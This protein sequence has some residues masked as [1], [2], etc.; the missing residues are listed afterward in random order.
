MKLTGLILLIAIT[1]SHSNLAQSD[2]HTIKVMS[3]NIRCAAC[4]K[5]SDINH[6]SK[7]KY[8]TAELIKKY[9]P[10]LIGLQEAEKSQIDDLF[11]LLDGYKWIGVGRDDGKETGEANAVFY[12][13]D[14]F[15]IEQQNTLWLSE[16][17][18]VPSKG[19]DAA[20]NRTVTIAKV[21]DR[22]SDKHFYLFNT[23][24]DHVGETA[25]LES[26]MFMLNEIKSVNEIFPVVLTGDF[27]SIPGSEPYKQ[28]TSDSVLFNAREI[29]EQPHFGGI[30]TFNGFGKT[31]TIGNT[32]DYIFVN[33]RVKVISHGII[34]DFID[35]KYPS[36]HYPVLAEIILK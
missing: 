6:W 5:E 18:E 7:R 20:F 25:K 1:F 27:N 28:L 36:D 35:E 3:F 33:D 14:R 16:T 17:P 19:W 21:E 30:V 8:L 12:K 23:H 2:E 9:N 4:E 10:D 26:A 24:F 11:D 22:K 31:M 29:S 32:I 13:T 34:T 15:N